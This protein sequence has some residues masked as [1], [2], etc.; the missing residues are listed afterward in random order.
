MRSS[1]RWHG[2]TEKELPWGYRE[3]QAV[4]LRVSRTKWEQR[5]KAGNF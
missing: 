3:T 5:N 2:I 1:K 4:W